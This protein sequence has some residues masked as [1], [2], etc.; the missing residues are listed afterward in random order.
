[1]HLFTLEEPLSA[2]ED[3]GARTVTTC[4]VCSR[5]MRVQSGTLSVALVCGPRGVWLTDGNAILVGVPLAER[6]RSLA[7]IRLEPVEARWEEGMPAASGPPPVLLQVRASHAIEA[8]P[9]NVEREQCAC[10]AVR[11]VSFSPLVVR[12]PQ[13]PEA[14]AWYLAE[15]AEVTVLGEPLRGLLLETDPD[16]VFAAVDNE[17]L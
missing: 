3:G 9:L 6:L 2:I 10:G 15:S 12:G 16:L 5:G 17:S 14:A 11:R 7:G 4:P 8:S 13:N 1:M